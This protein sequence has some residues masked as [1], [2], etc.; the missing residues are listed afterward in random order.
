MIDEETLSWWRSEM[1]RIRT[2]YLHILQERE[3]I[4]ERSEVLLQQITKE[5]KWLEGLNRYDSKELLIKG[6]KVIE[7]YQRLENMLFD[8][9]IK[10]KDFKRSLKELNRDVKSRCPDEECY[11]KIVDDM[12][13]HLKSLNLI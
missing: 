5:E 9:Q 6:D 11:Q 3:K 1:T 13:K 10:L 2:G 12:T 4:E 8:M 7:K